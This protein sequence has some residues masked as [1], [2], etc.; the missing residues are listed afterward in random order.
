MHLKLNRNYQVLYFFYKVQLVFLVNLLRKK[1]SYYQFY[2]WRSFFEVWTQ[3]QIVEGL[4]L[5][6]YHQGTQF[7]Q[8]YQIFLKSFLLF[9]REVSIRQIKTCLC[10]E[11]LQQ[12]LFMHKLKS[13]NK[14]Q[15]VLKFSQFLIILNQ[16]LHFLL[17]KFFE[18]LLQNSS[19][20]RIHTFK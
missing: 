11:D 12:F 5:F 9:R 4:Q 19:Y 6:I 15:T 10:Q 16:E 2:K 3:N 17:L 1:K 13:D 7:L 20:L 18:Y 14:P 8:E